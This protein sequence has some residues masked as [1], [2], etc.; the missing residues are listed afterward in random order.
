MNTEAFQGEDGLDVNKLMDP[1]NYRLLELSDLDIMSQSK[2]ICSN[3]SNSLNKLLE[4]FNLNNVVS[5]PAGID[6]QTE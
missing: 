4:E 5:I 1:A 6:W 3:L 2:I